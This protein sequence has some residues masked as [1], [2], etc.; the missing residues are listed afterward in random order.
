MVDLA[1]RADAV[2]DAFRSA[3]G[4]AP[5]GVWAAPGRVNLLGEHTDYEDGL[6]LPVAVD[7][8]ALAAV[9][10]RPG[11]RLRCRSAELPG[12][13]ELDLD[14]IGPGRVT[15][16]PAY[17]VGAVWALREAGAGVPSGVGGL[18]VLVT[19]DVPLGAGLASSAALTC[20]VA[21]AVAELAGAPLDRR[22]LARAA[23]RAE[24]DV[25]GAPVGVMDQLAAVS[26]RAG[27]ALLLDCRSLDVTPL[28]L[29]LPQAGLR[30]V[31]VDT[32]V[33]HAHAGGE[34]AARRRA[35]ATAAQRLRVP[36][37]RDAAL[38]DVERRLDGEPRRCARHVVTE[39]ARVAAAPALVAALDRTDAQEA[40]G[41]L[42]AASHASLR[43]DLRVSCPEL[44]AAV[45]AL[46]RGGA[47]AA[48]MTGGGF[49]GCAVALVPDGAVA[50]LVRDVPAAVRSAG[51]RE[52]RVLELVPSDGARRVG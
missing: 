37:L 22:A 44:D 14:E 47:V 32:R 8:E 28:P 41:A 27:C 9:A 3:Y 13:Y 52:P 46:L 40:L 39:N 43:D 36:A 51:L 34:Y 25:V 2:R 19:S 35:C 23:R 42:F 33:A 49:G 38:A 12:A 5:E 6:A 1:A 18:D 15:G 7:R 4:T 17:V 24:T 10:R 29:R 31:V 45:A 16:W 48:R 30:L 21:L 26:G 11:G 20:A 50:G